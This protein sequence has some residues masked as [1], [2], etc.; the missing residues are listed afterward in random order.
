MKLTLVTALAAAMALSQMTISTASAQTNHFRSAAPQA[1]SQQDLQNYGLS[2]ADASQVAQMQA[3][4]Y[5]V[6][7]MTPEEAHR[8]YGGQWSQGTWIA[9]GVVA[10]IV[11]AVA[12]SN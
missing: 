10:L 6:Q 2:A 7:V 5:H 11:I 3:K 12:V 8:V 4:G 9:I 1:F